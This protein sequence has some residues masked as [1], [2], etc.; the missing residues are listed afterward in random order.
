M[1]TATYDRTKNEAY[2]A[3]LGVEKH[4]AK[5]T[6]ERTLRELIKLHVSQINGCA[7]C[8]DM[9]VKAALDA[10]EDPQRL[11]LLAAW[12]E[13][14]L[15]TLRERAALAWTE[16]V[17][18]L[19]TADPSDHL[20]DALRAQFSEAEVVQLTATIA[21]INMWNRIAVSFRLQ[22]PSG[23]SARSRS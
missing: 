10:G 3:M 15:F 23:M 13:T 20:Y 8:I 16:A 2:R 5:C 14:T 12:R 1:E 4:L 9:H 19:A 21:T 11:H 18:Q 22:P 7:Y 17:T 6:I